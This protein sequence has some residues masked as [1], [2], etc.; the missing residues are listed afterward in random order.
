MDN[1]L[2]ILQHSLGLDQYGNGRQYRNHFATGPGGVDFVLCIEL[3][4]MGL[5]K[6]CG[7]RS[8]LG[9]M[10]CFV[11]TREGKKYIEQNSPKPPPIPKL[12]ASQKRYREYMDSDP[13]C[14]FSDWLGVK[15]RCDSTGMGM[16]VF[17]NGE[18]DGERIVGFPAGTIKQANQDRL[19]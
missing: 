9:D 18:R 3:A 17:H 10:H 8:F 2:H 19:D 13:G 7:T 6:D 14:S 5:M 11:V 16:Y 15:S 12:T 1:K 4:K